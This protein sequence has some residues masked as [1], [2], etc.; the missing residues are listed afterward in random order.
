VGALGIDT[1]GI[2]P[3][4]DTSFGANRLLLREHRIHLENL[5][6]PGRDAAVRRLDHRGRHPD[7]GRFRLT[8]HRVRADPV[9]GQQP[10]RAAGLGENHGNATSGWS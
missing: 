4:T 8:G 5:A 7:T 9:A 1:M 10:G 6:R 2:D 3:G